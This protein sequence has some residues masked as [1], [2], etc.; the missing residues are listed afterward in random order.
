MLFRSLSN[1]V[2]EIGDIPAVYG[3]SYNEY[4]EK[5]GREAPGVHN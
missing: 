4:V 1:R 3:G 5:T 2:L